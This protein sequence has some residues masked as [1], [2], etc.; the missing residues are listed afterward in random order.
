MME[1]AVTLLPDPDSPTTARVSPGWRSKDTSSTAAA[2]PKAVLNSVRK[3][4]T[5]STGSISFTC[6]GICISMTV[7]SIGVPLLRTLPGIERLTNA[8][9]EQVK[10]QHR[11]DDRKSGED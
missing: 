9:A 1:R 11:D 4:S 6:V 8:V 7:V 10:A 3:P 5:L 2:V